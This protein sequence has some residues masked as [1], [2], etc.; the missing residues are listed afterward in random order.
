[1]AIIR[2]LNVNAY[3]TGFN[4]Q[5]FNIRK[6]H[7]PR[8]Y[9]QYS[10]TEAHRY[11]VSRGTELFLKYGC[12]TMSEMVCRARDYMCYV[13][14]NHH[15]R[16]DQWQQETYLSLKVKWNSVWDLHNE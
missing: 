3:T 6:K 4:T 12:G 11:Y 14:L 7:S 5:M 2:K 16:I 15:Y 13:C 8:P 9:C 10:D 1:M